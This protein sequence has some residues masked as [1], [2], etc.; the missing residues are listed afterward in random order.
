[1]PVLVAGRACVLQVPC[2]AKEGGLSELRR[3]SLVGL[4]VPQFNSVLWDNFME[5]DKPCAVCC[6]FST[7]DD[8]IEN[9]R[10]CAVCGKERD[11]QQFPAK[12]EGLN[13]HPSGKG[14]Q[15]NRPSGNPPSGEGVPFFPRWDNRIILVVSSPFVNTMLPVLQTV[16][17]CIKLIVA[18]PQ[19]VPKHAIKLWDDF[20]E[21][22]MGPELVS[23]LCDQNVARPWN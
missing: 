22:T 17:K 1:M 18:G 4:I 10:P 11:S 21:N 5:N 8:F 14:T 13:I 23:K 16:H 20:I 19:A 15:R 7:W 6:S 9:E 3:L 12:T 2:R